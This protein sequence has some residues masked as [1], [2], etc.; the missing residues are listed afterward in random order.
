M[1]KPNLFLVGAMKSGTTTLH[2]LLAPH[3][4]I[5]MSEPKEPCYFVDPEALR[6]HWP[7]MW[8]MGIWKSEQ[9]YLALFPNKAGAKYLGESSTDYSKAPK[10]SG[11]VE[12]LA[13]YSPGARIV[14]I[15]RDP[16]ERTISHYWHMAEHR[17][18]MRAPLAAIS[19]D[20]HYTEVSHYALQLR[21]YIAHFGRE[22]VY[23]L[24]F[25]ALKNDPLQTVLALYA[26]LGVDTNFAPM[27]LHG[28]RN[29]T[30]EAVRQKRPG[31]SMLDRF[32]HSALWDK[33]GGHFPSAVR[34]LGVALVEKPVH[35]RNVDLSE[36]KA[37]LRK[38]QVPQAEELA[39]LLG[40][41]FPEWKTLYGK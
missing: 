22:H 33:V 11:V 15:M 9:A 2:E 39:L 6:T 27:D 25:E 19:Q 1:N 24:T 40:R 35:P 4:Q 31:R 14:Y 18:E 34:K 13:A 29:A 10:L 3:P 41:E 20:P 38:L 16:V 21:P 12:K 37:Y 28:A 36:V 7:E 5:S 32:R 8:R 30:P 26:W 17:G 23:A